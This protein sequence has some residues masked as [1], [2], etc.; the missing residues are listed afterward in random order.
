MSSTHKHRVFL[1][2]Q[3]GQSG[4]GAG[5]VT[6]IRERVTAERGGVWTKRRSLCQSSG[7]GV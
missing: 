6:P 5:L 2:R 1:F 7:E 3:C 4:D